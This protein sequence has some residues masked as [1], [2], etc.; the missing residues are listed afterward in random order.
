MEECEA[1]DYHIVTIA[2]GR[3]SA[4]VPL[5]IE[6]SGCTIGIELRYEYLYETKPPPLLIK[7][8]IIEEE[9]LERTNCEIWGYDISAAGFNL[10]KSELKARTHFVQAGV[11]G[12]NDTTASPP[13]YTIQD[14]MQMNGHDY[15]DILK[16]DIEY[17]EFNA[18]SSLNAHTQVSPQDFPIGQMLIEMHLLKSQGITYPIFLNWWESMEYRGLR[19]AWTE[20]NLL[21]VSMGLEDG[22][23]RVAEVT[24]K[25][26][27]GKEKGEGLEMQGQA[28]IYLVPW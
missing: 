4:S 18:L 28:S 19:P 2:L 9:M 27:E 23:A 14:L 5:V 7:I 17:A 16:I 15:I 6:E 25:E 24:A 12:N 20:P 22:Q 11:A 10:I 8:G 26:E 1:E 21:A 13:T 3:S